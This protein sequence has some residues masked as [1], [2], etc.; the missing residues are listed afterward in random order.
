MSDE[1]WAFRYFLLFADGLSAGDVCVTDCVIAELEKLGHRYRLALHLAKDERFKRLRCLHSGT[2]AD[3]CIVQ[4]VT[5]VSSR[6]IQQNLQASREAGRQST[7]GR[8]R[9]VCAA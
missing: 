4:R 7:S 3:D 2:Y 8:P 9:S 1:V 5:E 6:S